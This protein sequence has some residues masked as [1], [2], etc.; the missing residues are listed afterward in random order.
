MI[1]LVLT[2]HLQRYSKVYSR[3]DPIC[4]MSNAVTPLPSKNFPN[5]DSSADSC[6]I[7]IKG[8]ITVV[9]PHNIV[10]LLAWSFTLCWYC[11]VILKW[12]FPAKWS[13]SEQAGL[14]NNIVLCIFAPVQKKA[15][16]SLMCR[17]KPEGLS[18]ALELILHLC[19]IW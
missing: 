19:K 17:A 16:M 13:M 8:K 9:C 4:S 12:L 6:S 15:S 14:E 11:N 18:G 5:G 1:C 2:R 7:S 10:A 3:T